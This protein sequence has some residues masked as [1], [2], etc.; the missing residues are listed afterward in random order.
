MIN[1]KLY[2]LY[3]G[4]ALLLI[5]AVGVFS[6]RIIRR[7]MKLSPSVSIE[8]TETGL[9]FIKVVSHLCHAEIFLQGG[10]I[11]K[12][13]PKNAQPLLWVS[14]NE[15][16]Q[17]GMSIRGGIPVCWPWFGAHVA[18]DWPAHGF[19]RTSLWQADEVHETEDEIVISLQLP[20]KLVNLIHW[21]YESSLKIDFILT[22][23]LQVRLTTM[24]LGRDPFSFTQALHSYFPTSSIEKTYVDGL[25]GSQY[26]E[27][28][29]GPFSQ[30]EQVH[31]VRETDRVYTQA[32]STQTI[33]TPEGK[34]S[35]SRE[36]STSC[37][38]WNPWIEKSKRLSNFADDE[39]HNMICL[40]AANVLD[41]FVI[42]A[43]QQSHTLI[44]TISWQTDNN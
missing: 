10:Q 5:E 29:A 8:R 11:T 40:E 23:K 41:D 26:M 12:F 7:C 9:E 34:I 28:G 3:F 31:F 1:I 15:T 27:F 17:E 32:A 20:M 43:P 44:T 30:N 16:Y 25:Q 6:T 36:N 14:E 13:I 38:L 19:A 18:A 24:N 33:H 21:P 35:V 2:G 22:D 4:H 39:Y 37:V 42:L